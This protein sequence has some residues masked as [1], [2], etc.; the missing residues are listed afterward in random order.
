MHKIDSI[1]STMGKQKKALLN[2]AIGI[3]TNSESTEQK[4]S[5]A[6]FNENCRRYNL[7]SREIDIAKLI[8]EG[9]KYKTIADELFISERTVTKHAQNIFEKLEVS[10]KIELINKLEG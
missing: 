2:S 3:L 8:C 7:T 6:R 10:N 4:S 9:F 1:L 5:Q